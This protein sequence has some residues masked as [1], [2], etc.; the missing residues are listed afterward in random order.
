MKKNVKLAFFAVYLRNQ[1]LS[2][3]KDIQIRLGRKVTK[4]NT[5]TETPVLSTRHPA[6][7]SQPI[8]LISFMQVLPNGLRTFLCVHDRK[9]YEIKKKRKYTRV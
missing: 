7:G 4:I 1:F 2:F 6:E 5:S 8:R 3:R 9:R